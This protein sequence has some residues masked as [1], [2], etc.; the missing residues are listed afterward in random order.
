MTGELADPSAGRVIW[1]LKNRSR[2]AAGGPDTLRTAAKSAGNGAI[3]PLSSPAGGARS[4]CVPGSARLRPEQ[5]RGNAAVLLNPMG[6]FHQTLHILLHALDRVFVQIQAFVRKGVSRPKSTR[7]W[8]LVSKRLRQTRPKPMIRT[9]RGSWR[10]MVSSR[11]V[12]LRNPQFPDHLELPCVV[13]VGVFHGSG[14]GGCRGGCS[15]SSAS[16]R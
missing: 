9:T 7:M 3:G 10:H 16:L 5:A 6:K 11:F 14:N 8:P 13:I 2:N 15:S 4:A 1:F 12:R